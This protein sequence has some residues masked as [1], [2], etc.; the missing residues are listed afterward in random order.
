[1]SFEW[2][3]CGSRKDSERRKSTQSTQIQSLINS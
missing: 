2:K 3:K 1:L